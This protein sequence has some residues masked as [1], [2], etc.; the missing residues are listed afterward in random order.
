M[1]RESSHEQ[2]LVRLVCAVLFIFLMLL[3]GCESSTE[4]AAS[5]QLDTWRSELIVSVEPEGATTIEDARANLLGVTDEDN[6]DENGSSEDAPDEDGSA[7]ADAEAEAAVGNAATSDEETR[8]DPATGSPSQ[9]VVLIARV[10]NREIGKWWDEQ[11]ATL[12]VSE[13]S[14]K[15]H[16][17][18]GADHDPKECPFCRSRWKNEDSM[19]FVRFVDPSGTTIPADARQLLNVDAED[20]IVIRGTGELD[21]DS[22]L[23]IAASEV[24][25]RPPQ[26]P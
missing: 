24:Y 16:Y 23:N 8:S 22:M 11:Q 14:P 6:D 3:A 13:G 5:P 18:A 2:R 9:E 19:A 15:S 7:N 1:H 17:N 12:V 25:I 26:S 10:G 20:F 21:E 4:T